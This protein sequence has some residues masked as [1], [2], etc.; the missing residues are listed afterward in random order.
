VAARAKLTYRRQ[1]RLFA[2][3]VFGESFSAQLP[4]HWR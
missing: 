3:L 4:C 2:L 1:S